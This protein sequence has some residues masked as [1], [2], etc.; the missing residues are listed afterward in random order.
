L[1]EASLEDL[2]PKDEF[3]GLGKTMFQKF[4]VELFRI[5]RSEWHSYYR[6]RPSRIIGYL[7]TKQRILKSLVTTRHESLDMMIASLL[8]AVFTIIISLIILPNYSYFLGSIE[9]V[10]IVVGSSVLSVLFTA[11]GIWKISKI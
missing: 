2:N 7:Q 9:I 3:L 5:I 6:A 11:Y 10:Y 4:E 1:Y 8:L